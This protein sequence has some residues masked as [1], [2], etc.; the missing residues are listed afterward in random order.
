M[1]AQP[2]SLIAIVALA[3]LGAG[4]GELWLRRAVRRDGRSAE[5]SPHGLGSVASRPSVSESL[6]KTE[7]GTAVRVEARSETPVVDASSSAD[8]PQEDDRLGRGGET[9]PQ[10][11]GGPG[12]VISAPH[13]TASLP[14]DPSP[15]PP[16]GSGA[17]IREGADDS[18]FLA[19]AEYDIS[20]DLREAAGETPPADPLAQALARTQRGIAAALLI[21]IERTLLRKQQLGPPP[22]GTDRFQIFG[23]HQTLGAVIGRDLE[24]P[25]SPEDSLRWYRTRPGAVPAPAGGQ[26]ALKL[27]REFEI[28]RRMMVAK[29]LDLI[30]SAT[31]GDQRQTEAVGYAIA[32]RKLV[33]IAPREVPGLDELLERASALN[34]RMFVEV[35]QL[36]R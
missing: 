12:G 5:S 1:R 14:D 22:W 8:G 23:S 34:E 18:R 11:K 16:L 30:F 7:P 13:H 28:T 20:I 15:W 36:L 33:L 27:L 25:A 29:I 21:D 9:A 32:D 6:T 31:Q 4:V 10:P 35:E 26:Y 17:A 24:P 2:R 19:R 3:G